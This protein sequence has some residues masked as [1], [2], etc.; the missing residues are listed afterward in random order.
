MSREALKRL[1]LNQIWWL[2][3]PQ[4]PLKP[5][6]GMAPMAS[7]LATA[8]VMAGDRRIEVLDL[9]SQLGTHYTV[10]TLAAITRLYP[11]T[12]FVWI[13]GADNL[14]QVRQW[15]QWRTI[16]HLM[17]IAVMDRPTYALPALHDLAARYFRRQRLDPRSARHLAVRGPPAWTYLPIPLNPNSASAIRASRQKN[18]HR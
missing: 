5:S 15:R 9:E 2:V 6:A 8:R 7:R 3:S 1:H 14:K 10:D 18:P 11:K 13:M 16:F 4:N 12:R 17:P